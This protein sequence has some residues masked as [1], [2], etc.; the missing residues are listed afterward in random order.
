MPGALAGGASL[1][2]FSNLSS[3]RLRLTMRMRWRMVTE[4]LDEA[5]GEAVLSGASLRQTHAQLLLAA[6]SRKLFSE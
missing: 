1:T 6:S 2:S 3:R 4:R 5:T